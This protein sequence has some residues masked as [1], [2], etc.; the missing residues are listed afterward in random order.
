MLR[1]IGGLFAHGTPSVV[2]C[3]LLEAVPVNSVTTGHLVAGESAA[4]QVVLADGAV[5]V[6]LPGLAIVIVEQ[7]GVDAHATVHAMPKILPSSNPTEAAIDTVV[8]ELFGSHPEVTNATV[9]FSK[10]NMT[11]QTFVAVRYRM[12]VKRR[13]EESESTRERA[14][15]SIVR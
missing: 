12:Q 15:A 9:I 14:A 7:E 8:R 11:R 3:K 6:V 4:E 13:K 2:A 10:L 1:R 5:A